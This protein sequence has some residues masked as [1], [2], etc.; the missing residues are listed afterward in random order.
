[1]DSWLRDKQPV[2]Q[3]F[4]GC[5]PTLNPATP[6]QLKTSYRDLLPLEPRDLRHEWSR[7]IHLR[8]NQEA[9]PALSTAPF[10]VFFL[11]SDK[12]P[13]RTTKTPPPV[14]GDPELVRRVQLDLPSDRL[15]VS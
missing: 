1:M 15:A 4:N 11:T 9:P 8:T 10:W 2:N 5:P 12:V 3:L 6:L 7:I 13:E 14:G